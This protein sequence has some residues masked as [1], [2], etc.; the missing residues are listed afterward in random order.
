MPMK[1][2]LKLDRRSIF[3]A[4][5]AML[6]LA[7]SK[8][9]RQE[10][11]VLETFDI[12]ALETERAQSGRPY[13]SFL[14]RPTL[15]TGLYVLPA[16]GEDGQSPHRTDEVYYVLSGRAKIRVEG[17]TR[18]VS[19]GSV[20]FVKAEAEHRFVDIEEDIHLLVFFD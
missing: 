19:T 9:P 6:G 10:E 7:A 13:L 5:A 16:G 11:S 14:E 4:L 8:P 18:A 17:E 15:R 1:W 20:I 3:S 12:E 2:S